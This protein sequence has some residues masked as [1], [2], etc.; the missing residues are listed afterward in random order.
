MDNSDYSCR[1]TIKKDLSFW[2]E[3]Y[4]DPMVKTY[5][6]SVG[7]AL[8]DTK[9]FWQYLNMC[10]RYVVCNSKKE[11]IG[12]FSIYNKKNKTA[13]F[14]IAMHPDF[15][16]KGLGNVLMCYLEATAKDFGIETLKADVYE[17]NIACLSLLKKNGFKKL[18]FLEKNI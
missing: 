12:G 7:E 15:K 4:S 17:E 5:M 10:D 11:I 2:R 14:G 1:R 16:N 13:E 9:D 6:V 18:I 8:T 3:I